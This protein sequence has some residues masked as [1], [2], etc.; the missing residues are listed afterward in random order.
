MNSS[1]YIYVLQVRTDGS[2]DRTGGMTIHPMTEG[3][4]R[5]RNM[6][7]LQSH[8]VN[9]VMI[10]MTMIMMTTIE[11]DLITV[12]LS[13]LGWMSI[14]Y[15]VDFLRAMSCLFV[16]RLG[17]ETGNDWQKESVFTLITTITVLR[18]YFYCHSTTTNTIINTIPCFHECNPYIFLWH[19]V[20]VYRHLQVLLN[21]LFFFFFNTRH[22]NIFLLSW[23]VRSIVVA[24]VINTT[25]INHNNE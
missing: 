16:R 18:Y 17:R 19:P 24:I 1:T 25:N 2:G 12:L 3:G 14:L 11:S 4:T 10:M 5:K 23:I 7:L 21:Y 22:E 9:M 13:L 15:T 20:P 6:L 8:Q